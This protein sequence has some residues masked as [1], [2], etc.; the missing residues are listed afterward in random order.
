MNAFVLEF[1]LTW[2]QE[3]NQNESGSG[4]ALWKAREGRLAAD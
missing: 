2:C 1:R 4:W 3:G